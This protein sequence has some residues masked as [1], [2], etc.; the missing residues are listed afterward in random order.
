MME[1]VVLSWLV[2]ELTD[3]PS[4]VALVGVSRMAPMFLLGLIA[5]S[6]ADRFSKKRLMLITQMINLTVVGAMFLVIAR[7]HVQAWHAF[8]ATFTMGAAWTLDFAARRSY[9]ADLFEPSQ[10]MNAVSLDIAALTGSG[11]I[12]PLLGGALIV[13]IGFDGAYATMFGF[14]VVGLGLLLF[15]RAPKKAPHDGP[16]PSIGSQVVAAVQAIFVNPTLRAT[17]I[18]TVSLNFFGF[19]YMQMVPVIAR[20]VL[21]VGSTLYGVLAAA[22]GLGS[23]VG[24]MVIASRTIR[25]PGSVYSFGALLML[26]AVFAFS[27]A[28][29]YPIALVAL[30]VAGLGMAGFATMQPAIALQAVPPAMRGRAMGAIALGIGASPLGMLV[31]GQLA[32]A[33]GPRIALA[34][35][36]G[37]GFVVLNALRF[38][39]PP[40]RDRTGATG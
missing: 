1:M 22:A 17:L 5:G 30:I 40:L 11:M 26:I 21:G 28:P 14:Y 7:G 6:V 32:E 9:F 23:L 25:R 34:L 12:G 16:Q 2:L 24:S 37:T 19:P 20:D 3:S 33:F 4:Q 10:L 35:L 27:F 36:S 8:L 38:V 13:L 29:G 31:V 15:L 18:V 39:L